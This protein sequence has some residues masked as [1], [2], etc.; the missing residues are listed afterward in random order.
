[1][2]QLADKVELD[3]QVQQQRSDAK[4]GYLF[5]NLI[6]LPG[7]RRRVDTT[8]KYA[9]HEHSS[10]RPMSSTNINPA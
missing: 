8:V 7:I 5:D 6:E 9:A 3:D 1:M 2:L 10:H 4:E